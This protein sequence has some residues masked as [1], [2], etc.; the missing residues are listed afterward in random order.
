M[1]KKEEKTSELATASE[2]HNALATDMGM[3]EPRYR[4]QRVESGS[5]HDRFIVELREAINAANFDDFKKM[6]D[7][8]VST[9]ILTFDRRSQRYKLRFGI[10]KRCL[11]IAIPELPA[12][13]VLVYKTIEAARGKL[14]DW[15]A[16]AEAGE[17]DQALEACR[18]KQAEISAC[19]VKGR[20]KVQAEGEENESKKTPSDS[21]EAKPFNSQK[22]PEKQGFGTGDQF[23]KA[24]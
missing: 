8:L 17:F 12:D 11:R 22:K 1:M 23:A 2:E 20:K 18:A 14:G 10:G 24:A 3:T 4:Y 6:R 7:Q 9:K 13:Q 19:M 5:Y 15:L 21:H 16:R